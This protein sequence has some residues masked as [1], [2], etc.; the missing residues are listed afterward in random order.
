MNEQLRA[1]VTER[2]SLGYSKIQIIN[3]LVEAGYD[4]R[5]SGQIYDR[6]VDQDAGE[7]LTSAEKIRWQSEGKSESSDQVES[8]SEQIAQPKVQQMND[9]A[10]DA[11]TS[12]IENDD[13]A[14][15]VELAETPSSNS[16]SHHTG[17]IVSVV[18]VLLIAGVFI[19]AILLGWHQPLLSFISDINTTQ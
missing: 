4:A 3:E 2:V 12:Q 18:A 15:D 16:T 13:G 14:A 7:S 11:Q 1:A 9:S 10:V 8:D 17:L 6:V 19:A 5:E